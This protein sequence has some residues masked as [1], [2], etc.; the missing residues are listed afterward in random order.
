MLQP[1]Q[2]FSKLFGD[3]LKSRV[4][5][6]WQQ[7]QEENSNASET[8]TTNDRFNFHNKKMQEWYDESNSEAKEKVEEFRLQCKDEGDDN[9]D[10]NFSLQK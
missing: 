1:W 9:E 3:D 8:Y 2:A 10:P 7:Y 5:A 4:D 6:E